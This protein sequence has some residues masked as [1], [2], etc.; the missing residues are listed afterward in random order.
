MGKQQ[1][2]C[3]NGQYGEIPQSPWTIQENGYPSSPI[4]KDSNGETV[5]A[6]SQRSGH[7]FESHPETDGAAQL[8]IDAPGM[9]YLL[10]A[11]R[12]LYLSILD[13]YTAMR[14]QLRE[15]R[16]PQPIPA[17]PGEDDQLLA[18]LRRMDETLRTYPYVLVK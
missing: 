11:I 5:C 10:K 4:V 13:A 16:I 6:V 12:P 18:V 14:D 1:V 15:G 9:L 2:Q 7:P 3:R 8:I 17:Y